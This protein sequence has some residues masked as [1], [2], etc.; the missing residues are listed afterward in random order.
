MSEFSHEFTGDARSRG[1]H[2]SKGG[3]GG[4][5]M[6]GLRRRNRDVVFARVRSGEGVPKDRIRLQG[7]H[8]QD[9]KEGRFDGDL[10]EWLKAMDLDL[11]ESSKEVVVE[12]GVVSQ[13]LLDATVAIAGPEVAWGLMV[14]AGQIPLLPQSRKTR[15]SAFY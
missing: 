1:G 11:P 12:H 6:S 10:E 5:G 13:A 7:Y 4:D 14:V 3:D 2:A 9:Q 15:V 8:K